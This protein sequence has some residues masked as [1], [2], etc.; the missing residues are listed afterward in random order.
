MSTES[1]ELEI[2]HYYARGAICNQM[3]DKVIIEVLINLGYLRRSIN[4]D[5]EETMRITD[6]GLLYLDLFG[7][8]VDAPAIEGG[9]IAITGVRM[10]KEVRQ[11]P[12]RF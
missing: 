3:H 7:V 10:Q 2:L 12:F 6:Y 11:V 1:R 8:P 5:L 4:S 9:R